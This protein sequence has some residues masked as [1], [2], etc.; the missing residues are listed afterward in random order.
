VPI[1]AFEIQQQII[2]EVGDVDPQTGDPPADPASGIIATRM[3]YLWDRYAVY[4][5]VGPGLRELYARY[6]AIRLVLG[7]LSPRRFSH[8]D[9]RSGLAVQA[10]QLWQHYRL[11]LEATARE[12]QDARRAAAG[13]SGSAG[14]VPAAGP[15]QAGP[16]ARRAPIPVAWPPDPNDPRYGGLPPSVPSDPITEQDVTG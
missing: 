15:Y 4:D 7:V 14:S 6:G 10:D 12:I 8:S 1:T 3:H 16:I 11:M 2:L 13:A 5:Q 9:S